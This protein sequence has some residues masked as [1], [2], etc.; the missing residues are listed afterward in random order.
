MPGS[1]ARQ[2]SLALALGAVLGGCTG[3]GDKPQ[4]LPT[5]KSPSPASSPSP[6]PRASVLSRQSAISS[7]R[8]YYAEIGRAAA[9]GDT[10]AL[11]ALHVDACPCRAVDAFIQSSYKDG[12]RVEGFLYQIARTTVDS[13]SNKL[14]AINVTYSV[15]EVKVIDQSGRVK[16]AAP[17][18][19]QGQSVV[20]VVLVSDH[21]L[22]DH[23][24]VLRAR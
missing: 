6:T 14:A 19:Q 2:L 1:S 12:G 10:R 8:G 20:T 17:A 23:I 11:S 13:F 15:P 7:A 22:V 21:W 5:I 16:E 9:T 24:D 18:I 3:D 4:T